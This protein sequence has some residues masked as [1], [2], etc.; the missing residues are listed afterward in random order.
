L[1]RFDHLLLH[2]MVGTTHSSSG[3]SSSTITSSGIQR[4]LIKSSNSSHHR[5][6]TATI[7]TTLPTS[8]GLI[9]GTHNKLETFSSTTTGDRTPRSGSI[10]EDD[11]GGED[12]LQHNLLRMGSSNQNLSLNDQSL[13]MSGGGGGSSGAV[14]ISSTSSS[15]D[16]G[17]IS[18]H[19]TNNNNVS[20]LH[21]IPPFE[22]GLSFL[23]ID[24][25]MVR[26]S[27]TFPDTSKILV[28]LNSSGSSTGPSGPTLLRLLACDLGFTN[29]SLAGCI[30]ESVGYLPDP[31]S[32]NTNNN[33]N[34]NKSIKT[35]IPTTPP[36]SATT[37]TTSSST[38]PKK[39]PQLLVFDILVQKP[40]TAVFN[41]EQGP[42]YH[43]VL[44]FEPSEGFL[45]ELI[46][47]EL[48]PEPTPEAKLASVFLNHALEML[49]R[50]YVVGEILNPQVSNVPSWA[51]KFN[52]TSTNL[53]GCEAHYLKDCITQQ[54]ET[55]DVLEIQID[56]R[57]WSVLSRQV[58]N[59]ILPVMSKLDFQLLFYIRALK[60]QE[61]P[62]RIL[63]GA[64]LGF[65]DLSQ[66]KMWDF[67]GS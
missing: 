2:E 49:D 35:T 17:G 16:I 61:F 48:N 67:E 58:A 29:R 42:A 22:S 26:H 39:L 12:L 45:Q 32:I 1:T 66:V 44:V 25:P 50:L 11:S 3:S 14:G 65:L 62:E 46:V 7:T 31:T 47:D 4:N 60:E 57:K 10:S 23:P 28:R 34:N 8:N 53:K 18:T 5:S 30:S 15:S 38:P 9:L 24:R 43:L 55:V 21:H 13:V 41:T 33:N 20:I 36:S 64:R 37:T 59:A 40:G 56:L 51:L 19:T 27:W 63:C 6:A 54:G 52:N